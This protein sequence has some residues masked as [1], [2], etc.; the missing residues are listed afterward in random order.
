MFTSLWKCLHWPFCP[1]VF[2]ALLAF[3]AAAVAFRKNPGPRE[4]AL[5]IFSFLL[6]MCGEVWMM[7]IDRQKNEDQ[8]K[9]ANQTQ[10]NGFK[11]IGDGI[12]TSIDESDKNFAATIGKT[13]QILL[14]ITGGDSFG[15]VVPQPPGGEQVALIVW[16]HGDQPLTGV[17][18]TIAHTQEPDWGTAFFKPI[19]IGTIGPHDHAPVPT[20]LVPKPEEKSGQD[21]YWIMISAQNGTVSQSLWFRKNHKNPQFWAYSYMVTKE[22]ILQKARGAIPK[23]AT[24]MQPILYRNWSD[25]VEAPH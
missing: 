6:L 24:L 22:T 25:E 13:N 5:W 17:T 8:Q 1:G 19:F 23:G 2:I 10:L 4:R 15:F 7:G 14:N 20:F 16:N 11:A 21:N 9:Q 3:V 12:K 18:L